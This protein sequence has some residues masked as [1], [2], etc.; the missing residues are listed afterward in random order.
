MLKKSVGKEASSMEAACWR[1]SRFLPVDAP[2]LAG[3]SQ[4][5]P[6]SVCPSSLQERGALS[7]EQLSSEQLR[8]NP[9]H[10]ALRRPPPFYLSSLIS[11]LLSPPPSSLHPSSFLSQMGLS[12]AE[13]HR[14]VSHAHPQPV[15]PVRSLLIFLRTHSHAFMPSLT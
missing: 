14:N 5:P 11:S 4:P 8:P 12:E 6:P 7:L 10:P 3:A 1:K 15:S 9:A 13:G 2:C